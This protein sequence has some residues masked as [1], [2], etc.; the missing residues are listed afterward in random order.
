MLIS[1]SICIFVFVSFVAALL[2]SP[3]CHR[4]I[5]SQPQFHDYK[6]SLLYASITSTTTTK[7]DTSERMITDNADSDDQE[8]CDTN[9]KNEIATNILTHIQNAKQSTNDISGEM[10]CAERALI[11]WVEQCRDRKCSLPDDTIFGNVIEGLLALPSSF[12]F[13]IGSDEDA[14]KMNDEIRRSILDIGKASKQTTNLENSRTQRATQILDLMESFHEP[15][16]AL[17][18]TLIASHGEDALQCLSHMNREKDKEQQDEDDESK[19]YSS[20]Y[21]YQA[22]KSG[23]ASLKLLQRSEELYYE[24]GQAPIQL[25]SVSSYIIMMDVW[26]ALAMGVEQLDQKNKR[27]EALEVVRNL[28]QRRLKIYTAPTDD[29]D[30]IHQNSDGGDYNILPHETNTMT[31]EQVLNYA[32]NLLSDSVPSYQLRIKDPKNIGTW[33]YNQLMFDLA[34]LKQPFSGPLAQD[35]LEYMVYLVKKASPLSQQ[36]RRHQKNRL[37]PMPRL[38]IPKPNV[39]TINAV[40]KA[41]MVTP[42]NSDIARRAEA[43]LAKLAVWQSEGTLWGVNPDTVSYNTV[44]NIWKNS[45]VTGAAQRA[46]EI[47]QLFE[48]ES[49]AINPDVISYST[50]IGAWAKASSRDPIAGQRAEEILMRMYNRYKDANGNEIVAP[51]PSTRIFNSVFLAY[52]NGGQSGGGKRSLELLRFMERLNS[53]GFIDMSG[54]AVEPGDLSPDKFTFNIVMRALS[55]CGEK[56]ASRKANQLLERMVDSFNKGNTKLKPDLVSV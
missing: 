26:K 42:N 32:A 33:H 30:N 49:T 38:T 39:D 5:S 9:P 46:T 50:T 14:K 52:A 2:P 25:P 53:E 15:P 51:R 23:K 7:E 6:K 56:G 10:E 4:K 34:R 1:P 37:S 20:S 31:A 48:D 40:L 3:I 35:L 45:G 41:W 47:L 17:Y 36:H 43:V 21:Y 28:R 29:I 13:I 44:I 27:D 11:E 55:N 54:G 16:G 8:L 22:W 12:E 18:D 24:T 19:D